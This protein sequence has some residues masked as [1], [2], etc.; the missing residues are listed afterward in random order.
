MKIYTQFVVSLAQNGRHVRT[1]T[2]EHIVCLYDERI[3]EIYISISV[4]TIEAKIG[5]CSVC[6]RSLEGIVCKHRGSDAYNLVVGIVREDCCSAEGERTRHGVLWYG[7]DVV[8]GGMG[9]EYSDDAVQ[10]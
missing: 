7:D 4:Q 1:P 9:K 6:Q 3:V 10:D 5:R 8:G 2:T